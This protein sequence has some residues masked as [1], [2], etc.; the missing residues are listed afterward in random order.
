M[1]TTIE[2]LNKRTKGEQAKLNKQRATRME[3]D[4]AKYLK[5]NRVPMS[6]SGSIKGDCI[7]P[8][9]EY[10]SIYVECK[11]TEKDTKKVPI[12]W[13]EKIRKDTISMRCVF[14]ILVIQWLRNPTRI[15]LLSEEALKYVPI[16]I[17]HFESFEYTAKSLAVQSTWY[18]RT[19]LTSDG[20][21]IALTLEQFRECLVRSQE[22]LRD[23]HE[24]NPYPNTGEDNRSPLQPFGE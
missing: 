6:G 9:D 3:K 7:V 24:T 14:G 16:S 20:W 19:I 1:K 4:I 22:P 2:Q 13:L 23:T 18:D 8:F 11:F 10:R 17:A 12:T 15:V 21:W 5:G